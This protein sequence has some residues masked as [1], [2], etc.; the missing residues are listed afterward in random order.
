MSNGPPLTPDGLDQAIEALLL[1]SPMSRGRRLLG[2]EYE[3]LVLHRETRESAP[4]ELCMELF[5][6]LVDD[7]RATPERDGTVLNKMAGGDFGMSMEPGGQ[8]EVATAPARCLEDLD[9]II[10]RVT[11]AIDRRLADTPY[12]LVCLGHAPV[13][14]VSELGL[15]PRNRYRVMDAAMPARGPLTR[16]MMRATA[17]FLAAYDVMSR[18]DAGRKLALLYRLVPVLTAITANSREIEGKDSGYASFRHLVWWETDRDRSG[19]PDGCLHADTAID[20]YV[21]YARRATALFRL[22][23]DGAIAAS[24]GL[25]LEEWVAQGEVTLPELDLHLSSLFPFVRLRNYVEVRMFDSV[26]WPLARSVVALLSGILYCGRATERAETLSA[27]LALDDPGALRELHVAVAREGL[28]AVDPDGRTMRDLA[29]DLVEIAGGRLGD[30]DCNWARP[31]DLEAVR[32]HL[33]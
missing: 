25:S 19:V 24:P 8:L 13:T 10:A 7:L 30:K 29:R 17:G 28:A 22:D 1:G 26:E 14:P 20:G 2:V 3:R 15:L 33:A 32:A 9:G 27:P 12:E 31:E 4:L 5:A 11:E 16:N 6:Q 21:R 18:E 23:D